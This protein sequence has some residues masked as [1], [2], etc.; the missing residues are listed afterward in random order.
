MRC[1]TL[2]PTLLWDWIGGQIRAVNER[3][4]HGKDEQIDGDSAR[5]MCRRGPVPSGCDRARGP[6]LPG[7][8]DTL[9]S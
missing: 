8:C 7:L 5:R 1:F 4:L 9:L 6:S 3:R 2:H